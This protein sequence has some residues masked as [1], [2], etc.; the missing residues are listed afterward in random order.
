MVECV[1]GCNEIICRSSMEISVI[2]GD[3]FVTCG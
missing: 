3:T 1:V 2:A